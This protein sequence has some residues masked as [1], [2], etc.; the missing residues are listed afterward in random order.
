MYSEAYQVI[1]IRLSVSHIALTYVYLLETH[2]SMPLNRIQLIEYKLLTGLEH[3]RASLVQIMGC[4]LFGA[5]PFS[6]T[7]LAYF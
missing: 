7:M 4:R 6:E 1:L 3:I 2:N 5:K